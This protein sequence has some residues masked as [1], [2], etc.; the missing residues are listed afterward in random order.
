VLLPTN[1][2]AELVEKLP[3]QVSVVRLA[4]I[5]KLRFVLGSVIEDHDGA[6][7]EPTEAKAMLVEPSVIGSFVVSVKIL[8]ALAVPSVTVTAIPAVTSALVSASVARVGAPETAT[9]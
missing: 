9:T 5:A 2:I 1:F 8:S 6:P 4:A 7:P 3:A